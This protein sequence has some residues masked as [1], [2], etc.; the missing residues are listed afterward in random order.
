MLISDAGG[1]DNN[2]ALNKPVFQSSKYRPENDANKTVDGNRDDNY[3]HGSCTHTL[4]EVQP[5]IVVDLEGEYEIVGVEI[6][7]RGDC[8]GKSHLYF[9]RSCD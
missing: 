2:V 3:F 9:F 4:H 6:V 1:S 8:C 5:W 7:N